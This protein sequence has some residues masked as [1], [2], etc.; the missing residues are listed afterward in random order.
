MCISCAIAPIL[1]A[2]YRQY[3]QG[4]ECL[5]SHVFRDRPEVK[6]VCTRYYHRSVGFCTG[7]HRHRPV[8][9]LMLLAA[10]RAIQSFLG[11]VFQFTVLLYAPRMMQQA[12]NCS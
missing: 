2:S 11:L 1:P 9:L 7:C 10:C 6:A 3:Q 4:V 5:H 12:P 8:L